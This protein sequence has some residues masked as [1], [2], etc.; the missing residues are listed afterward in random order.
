M[1]HPD[2]KRYRKSVTSKWAVFSIGLNFYQ[3]RSHVDVLCACLKT[4]HALLCKQLGLGHL[5][6]YH[7]LDS[8]HV[9]FYVTRVFC[10]AEFEL[11]WPKSVRDTYSV[12]SILNLNVDLI[13]AEWY[14]SFSVNDISQLINRAR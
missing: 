6:R 3:V 2:L 10:L 12:F 11:N 7:T 13:A 8:L 4:K 5:W 14:L 9:V 1:K